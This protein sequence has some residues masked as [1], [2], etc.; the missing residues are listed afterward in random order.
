MYIEILGWIGTVLLVGAYY[1]L[2]KGAFKDGKSVRY[3]VMNLVGAGLVGL[4][5]FNS[6]AWSAVGLEVIWMFLAFKTLYQVR[7]Q[8]SS[9]AE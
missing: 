5:A 8:V 1:L 4:D 2:S 9:D 7:K 3:Q 6:G